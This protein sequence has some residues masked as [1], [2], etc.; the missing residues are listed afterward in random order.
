[1][2][3][4]RHLQFYLLQG[5]ATKKRKSGSRVEINDCRAKEH[6]T[7]GNLLSDRD[8]FTSWTQTKFKARLVSTG[9]TISTEDWLRLPVC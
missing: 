9:Q 4:F 6:E 3:H 5:E 1:M 8:T 2:N 7:V